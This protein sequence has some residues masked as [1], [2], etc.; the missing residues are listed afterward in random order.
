MTVSELYNSVAQLGFEDSLED[1]D[2]FFFAANRA[3]LQVNALRPATGVYA[4]YHDPMPNKVKENTFEPVKKYGELC[5]EA[6]GVKA[7]Y[8][9]ADGIGEMIAERWNGERWVSVNSRIL[10][11]YRTF[12]S[13]SGSI[14]EGEN[15]ISDLARLRFVGDYL[16]S[17]K[18]VAMYEHLLGGRDEDI[19]AYEPHTRYDMRVLA[20]D[21]LAFEKPTIRRVS[22]GEYLYD[23]YSIEN[24]GTV[25]L[26][27]EQKGLYDILYQRRPKKLEYEKEAAEDETKIDLDEDLCALLPV[28]IASYIW[29]DDEPEK[30][31]YYLDL[32]RER[33]AFVESRKRD[34]IPASVRSVNGW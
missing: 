2:R 4:L 10:N 17:V 23:G 11:S 14:P 16:Y 29:V 33:A 19:P 3:L 22:D 18:N 30:A 6:C 24:G 12:K 7:F 15:F 5:F 27:Y 31:A 25:L 34:P 1:D 26:P 8:F 13:Y 32:Y 20:T 21:F 28:L 9:E